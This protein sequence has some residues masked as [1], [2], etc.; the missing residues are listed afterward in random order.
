MEETHRIE[1]SSGYSLG[2]YLFNP[3]FTTPRSIYK[4]PLPHVKPNVIV[5]DWFENGRGDDES[6]DYSNGGYHMTRQVLR[7]YSGGGV[8]RGYRPKHA[9]Q[10]VHRAMNRVQKTNVSRKPVVKKKIVRKQKNK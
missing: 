8:V 5:P 2:E 6:V 3:G 9:R 1:R 10:R 7:D 4:N